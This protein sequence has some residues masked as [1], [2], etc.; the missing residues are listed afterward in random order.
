MYTYIYI[1]THRES[2]RVIDR[3]TYTH[4]FSR[5]HGWLAQ[6]KGQP[7]V[8]ANGLL[9][10]PRRGSQSRAPSLPLRQRWPQ[11]DRPV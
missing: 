7:P 4:S 10:R 11:R 5:E 8:L 9:P 1:Y 6:G 3:C 2:E